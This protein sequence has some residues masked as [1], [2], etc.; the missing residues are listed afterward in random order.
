[1]W[2]LSIYFR[3][4][5]CRMKRNYLRKLLLSPDSKLLMTSDAYTEVMMICFPPS[6]SG[7]QIQP[8][9]FWDDIP[10]Y[11]DETKKVIKAL[12][13]EL[14]KSAEATN[15]PI[16]IEYASEEL[17]EGTIAYH[18][19]KGTILSESYYWF[20]TKQFEQ[21]LLSA[22]SNPNIAS[23]FVHIN[24]GGGEA[25]YMD[26]ISERM[27]SLSKPVYVLFEKMGGSAAYYIG[28]HGSVVKALTQNDNIGCIG[29][30]I[31]FY[32]FE[33]Y[34]KQLG[35]NKIEEYATV[36]DLKNKKYRDLKNGKPEQ[37][38]EEELN[39][40]SEQFIAE[41][42]LA[43]PVLTKL[44]EDDPVFRGETFDAIT[45]Q[46]KGLIDG[47]TTLADAVSEA[48]QLGQGWLSTQNTR[49]RAIN[50]FNNQFNN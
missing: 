18:R 38:I 11:R 36:S 22:E 50:I 9:S 47:I 15:I 34:Y 35:I 45:A 13:E 27:R 2:F 43:R 33:G 8:Q 20:S 12:S 44:P 24:S 26:R 49:S 46:Q 19:I 30:M 14:K 3:G 41:V 31:S 32:D 23:H 29:T 28:C 42:K 21:D 25:W 5:D 10:S 17:P 7:S 1:M 39:P 40:L 37:Y 6:L 48:Y 16:S 4:K